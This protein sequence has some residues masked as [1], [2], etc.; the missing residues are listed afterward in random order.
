MTYE[1]IE[2][3]IRTDQFQRENWLILAICILIKLNVSI[4]ITDSIYERE[5]LL[6]KGL[7]GQDNQHGVLWQPKEVNMALH[8]VIKGTSDRKWELFTP[9]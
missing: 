7:W 3:L 8:P 2:L 6:S 4:G 5:K 9:Q 1:R